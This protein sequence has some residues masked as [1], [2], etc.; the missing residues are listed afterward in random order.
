MIHMAKIPGFP[1]YMVTVNGEVLSK[2]K[3][4]EPLNPGVIGDGYLGVQLYNRG[5]YKGISLHRLVAISFIPNPDNYST[6]NH[7]D[8][9]KSNNTVP[10]LKW[11]PLIANIHKYKRN[12][13]PVGVQAR[14]K[15]FLAMRSINCIVY[16]S[17][18]LPTVE[19]AEYWYKSFG[20][21]RK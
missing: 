14:G 2:R 10:N 7:E 8:E 20:Q 5:Y 21:N 1:N 4:W 18:G 6:V 16:F 19:A 13:L 9:D 15:I 12:G 3:G 17:K 11:M